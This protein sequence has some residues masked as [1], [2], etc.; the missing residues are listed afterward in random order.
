[1]TNNKQEIDRL[2]KELGIVEEAYKHRVF[3]NCQHEINYLNYMK[4]RRHSIYM[5]NIALGRD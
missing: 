2:K 4:R 1:M 5:N 3:E